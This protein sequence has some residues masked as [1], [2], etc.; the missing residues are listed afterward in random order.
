MS[1]W[2]SSGLEKDARARAFWSQLRN[3]RPTPQVP[4]WERIATRIGQHAETAVRGLVDVDEMLT[5]LDADADMI[6][7]K[8]RS[9]LAARQT[10]TQTNGPG[11]SPAGK[12]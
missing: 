3:V 8:R 2:T 7:E 1:A 9:L 12:H 6:L 5:R 10:E 4:E 11:A